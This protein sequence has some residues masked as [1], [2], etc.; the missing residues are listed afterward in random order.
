MHDQACSLQDALYHAEKETKVRVS[1]F[2]ALVKTLYS[3]DPDVK[4]YI[5][6]LGMPHPVVFRG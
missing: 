1:E 2:M 5:K 6:D 3:K 4:T